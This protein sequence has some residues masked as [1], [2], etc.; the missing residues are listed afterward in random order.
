M[1]KMRKSVFRSMLG[2]ICL[3]LVSLAIIE[4]QA[5]NVKR[6]GII[7]KGSHKALAPRLESLK[8]G[9]MAYGYVEGKNVSFEYRFANGCFLVNALVFHL[10]STLSR[11]LNVP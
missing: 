6:V 10:P 3:L 9:M 4:I 8:Q 7:G 11:S 1:T 5:D 2:I